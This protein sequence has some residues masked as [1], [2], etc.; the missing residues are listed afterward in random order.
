M[1]MKYASQVFSNSVGAGFNILYSSGY[2]DCKKEPNTPNTSEFVLFVNSLFDFVNINLNDSSVERL[3]RGS[4]EQI[5]FIDESI[6]L[7]KS[8]QVFDRLG[9]NITNYFSFLKGWVFDLTTSKHFWD[10]ISGKCDGIPT[11]RLNQDKIE[12]FFGK[13]RKGNVTSNKVTPY[14]FM[15]QFRKR[16]GLKFLNVVQNGNCESSFIF[17]EDNRPFNTVLESVSSHDLIKDLS[18]DLL[19]SEKQMNSRI[20]Y[21]AVDFKLQETTFMQ[22]NAFVYFCG[23]LYLKSFNHHSCENPLPYIGEEDQMNDSFLFSLKKRFDQ[24]SLVS[25]LPPIFL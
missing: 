18:E 8:I 19:T 1:K 10:S 14:L 17:G 13:I 20:P 3:F 9:H 22:E 7:I 24:Y 21:A 16:W 15:S 12:H 11:R 4:S 6:S 23:W 25:H 2:I 5:Q